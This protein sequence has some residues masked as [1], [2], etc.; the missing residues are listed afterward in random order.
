M[1]DPGEQPAAEQR[2]ERGVRVP[3]RDVD[4]RSTV[5]RFRPLDR[6]SVGRVLR[7]HPEHGGHTSGTEI[8]EADETDTTDAEPIHR[9]RTERVGKYVRQKVRI[10][11]VI[12][13]NT[14]IDNSPYRRQHDTAHFPLEYNT[15]IP[16]G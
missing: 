4:A 16:L 8:T 1:M 2:V 14:A 12:D 3:P 5:A 13:E 11:P 9:L 6:D 10:D 7:S 15:R